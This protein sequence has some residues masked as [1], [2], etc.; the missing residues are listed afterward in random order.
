MNYAS[1]LVHVELE[2]SND[3]VLRVAGGLAAFLGSRVI[4]AAA[5]D[6]EP[7]AYAEGIVA[8]G[9]VAQDRRAMAGKMNAA[10]QRFRAAMA[11]CSVPCEWRQGF[12]RP[13]EFVARH[14]RAADLLIAGLGCYGVLDDPRYVLD[15]TELVLKA[16]RPLLV[17]PPEVQALSAQRIVVGWKNTRE[18]RRAI[19]DA[20]PLLRTAAQVVVAHVSEADEGDNEAALDDVVAWLAL[21]QVSASKRVARSFNGTGETLTEIVEDERADLLVVGAYGHSRVGE[22]IWGGVSQK[23]LTSSEI[24]CL[25][26]H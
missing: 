10:E 14:G 19:W 7:P 12:E 15:P 1:L 20:L 13:A 5:N 4:G 11:A 22:W 26:S 16:G 25:F 21:H 8:A 6:P 17:V 24:C 9:L 23:L 18:A 2:P 3:A